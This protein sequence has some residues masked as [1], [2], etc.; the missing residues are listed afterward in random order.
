[1]VVDMKVYL[2]TCALAVL[3]TCE[4]AGCGDDPSDSGADGGDGGIIR[5]GI[6]DD[7][8]TDFISSIDEGSEDIDGDGVANATDDDSDGDGIADSEEGGDSDC[9]TLPIDLDEDGTPDFLDTDA[10]ADGVPDRDQRDAD[11]DGDTIIDYRDLDVDGDGIPNPIELGDGDAPA[12]TDSDGIA[13]VRDLDSDGDSILDAHE[14]YQDPDGD[15]VATFRDLESDGDGLEDRREAGD[16]DLATVPTACANEINS[17]TGIV[18]SDSRP[19][20]IDSDSDNDGLGDGEEVE[21]GTDICGVDSDGDGLSDLA[22]AAYETVN[23]PDHTTG[24][25]CGCATDQACLIPEQH[26]YVVLPYLGDAVQRDL[27]FGTTIRVAD[28]FF[29]TDTTGSMSSTLMRVKNT[30]TTPGSGLIDRIRDTIPDVWF[31]GG[32]HDD[33]PFALYGN[34]PDQ[35]FILAI[36]MTAPADAT[37][38]Q[39]AFNGMSIHGGGDGPE[40]STEAL[41]QIITGEGGSWTG[42]ASPYMMRA[43]NSDCM[44]IGYGAACFR[45]AALPIIVHFTDICSHNGPP[46]EST[47]CD[48]YVGIDPAPHTWADTMAALNRRGAK[49]IGI[50]VTSGTCIG[51]VS[52][53]LQSPCYFMHRTAQATGSV[54]IALNDLVY[55]LPAGGSSDVVFA[56]TVVSGIET[57]ATRVPLDVDTGLRDDA[58]DPQGVDAR[59]FIKRRQPGC[60]AVPPVD[61]C[62]TAAMGVQ[63]ADAVARVDQ[64][65]FFGAIPGTRV[66]FRIT[67]QNDFHEGGLTAQVFI[68]YIDVRGGGSAI[69]DT[70]QVFIIVPAN[71]TFIPG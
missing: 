41:Y 62:W 9:T 16:D 53:S 55:D 11:E 37:E 65:T 63:H 6:G 10:N 22:E 45:E 25:D 23:C 54:D 3:G 42:G 56:D 49:Y 70:R 44:G 35:P 36:G 40:S 34:P 30:V 19:D 38:V 7:P 24:T 4:L 47:Q 32:Q 67:F 15:G 8:D 29:V 13:D 28:V 27:E 51:V 46:G 43:Y 71:S 39:S 48:P 60:T 68:A 18:E 66:L 64:S 2:W 59:M 12:D 31:G 20:F 5:C 26:Y 69:L 61:P 17:T 52:G 58:S 57:V 50:N 1:M 14:G 21:F 33:F